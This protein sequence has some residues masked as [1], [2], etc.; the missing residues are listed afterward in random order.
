MITL[1]PHSKLSQ[2]LALHPDVLPFIINRNPHDFQ[3]LN[4]AL[5][6]KL[7][8]PRITLARLAAMLDEPVEQLIEGIYAAAHVEAPSIALPSSPPEPVPLNANEPPP[9]ITDE[10]VEVIDLLA[11]DER[12]DADPFVAIFP[13]LKRAN[14]GD[15][16]LLKHKWEPQPLYDVWRK[17]E[18]EYFARQQSFNEWWIYLRKR[19]QSYRE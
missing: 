6:R 18:V 3:R 1:E 7:M 15:L 5:M 17:L 8:P 11:S 13:A 9:W 12:L 10:V 19:K 4:N 2:A 14:V 16:L